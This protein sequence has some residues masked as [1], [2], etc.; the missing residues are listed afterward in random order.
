MSPS[1]TSRLHATGPAAH[2]VE[3]NSSQTM[4]GVEPLA[5]LLRSLPVDPAVQADLVSKVQQRMDERSAGTRRPSLTPTPPTTPAR[6]RTHLPHTLARPSA[7]A[8]RPADEALKGRVAALEDQLI[9]LSQDVHQRRQT[10]PSWMAQRL[11]EQQRA[12]ISSAA[13]AAAAPPREVAAELSS[14]L[15]QL[16]A[17]MRRFTSASTRVEEGASAVQRALDQSAE[18]TSQIHATADCRAYPTLT[19]K[20]IEVEKENSSDAS[21]GAL[22]KHVEAQQLRLM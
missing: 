21:M 5:A 12:T 9:K 4:A 6:T 18:L 16:G 14:A 20:A 10:L 22:R 8:G 7:A 15:E 1:E 13:A 17:E 3:L 2:G 11:E 19:D